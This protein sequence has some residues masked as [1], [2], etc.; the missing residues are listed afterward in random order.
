MVARSFHNIASASTATILSL[1]R[2]AHIHVGFVR[3]NHNE[4]AGVEVDVTPPVHRHLKCTSAKNVPV[5]ARTAKNT[6]SSVVIQSFDESLMD[7]K[8]D[9]VGASY[10]L[11]HKNIVIR[12]PDIQSARP[13]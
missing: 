1:G 4:L 6:C 5:N 3:V 9:V 8:P 12:R 11:E 10:A 2:N 7:T 13:Q